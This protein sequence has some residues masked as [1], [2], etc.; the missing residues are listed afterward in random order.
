MKAGLNKLNLTESKLFH[1]KNHRDM[2]LEMCNELIGDCSWSEDGDSLIFEYEKV[3][4]VEVCLLHL[5][6][7]LATEINWSHS[8]AV[9]L[10][11]HVQEFYYKPR[12][13]VDYLY[14]LYQDKTIWKKTN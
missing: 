12:H 1:G 5:P 8:I 2:L 10:A 11:L 14:Q 13:I 3:G 6:K 4:W 7:V 9:N